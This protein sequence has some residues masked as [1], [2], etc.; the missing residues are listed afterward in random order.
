M[1]F[2]IFTAAIVCC[3]VTGCGAIKPMAFDKTAK[4]LDTKEKSILLMTLEVSRSDG[5]RYVPEPFN[6]A[7]ET[8][9]AKSSDDRA[10]FQLNKAADSI[11]ENGKTLYLARMAL[12]GGE[13][14]FQS[15]SGT[16]STFPFNAF[17]AVPLAMD[18]KVKPNSVT[19]IGRVTAKMRRRETGEFRAGP[20]FPLVDQGAAGMPRSTWEIVVEDKSEADLAL[21]RAN[22]PVLKDVNIETGPIPK[23]DRAAA[24]RWSQGAA[25][26]DLK[27][28]APASSAAAGA[29]AAGK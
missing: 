28:D 2:R 1:M 8:P 6:M 3:V 19:Y 17:F 23:F 9:T 29:P 5:S 10:F 4:T 18:V 25:P 13:Y 7:F 11:Q 16:A 22:Y 20:M 24:H 27:E 21:F 26:S 14:K 12:V 15:V